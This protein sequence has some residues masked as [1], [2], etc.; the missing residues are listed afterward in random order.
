MKIVFYGKLADGI[1]REIDFD[2]GIAV[3]NVGELRAALAE[4]WP[5]YA[6]DLSGPRVKAMIADDVVSDDTPLGRSQTIE[7]FP[8]VSGG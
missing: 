1:G 2:P 4:A 7:F 8:P 3:R 6:A 5:E